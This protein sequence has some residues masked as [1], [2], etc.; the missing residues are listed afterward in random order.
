MPETKIQ[1]ETESLGK[2]LNHMIDFEEYK[3]VPSSNS[4]GFGISKLDIMV[5]INRRHN[6]IR[7]DILRKL[8]DSLLAVDDSDIH[9]QAKIGL[10]D[11]I[12][13]IIIN[14]FK[15]ITNHKE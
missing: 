13:K 3:N 2:L 11:E 6:K 7:K 14:E 15:T 8:Q 4:T 9:K 5:E 1:L 12:I 10:Y